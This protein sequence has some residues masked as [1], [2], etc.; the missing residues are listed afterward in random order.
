MTVLWYRLRPVPW[1]L[2]VLLGAVWAIA[3]AWAGPGMGE[4][5]G[6]RSVQAC[7][8]VLGL[9]GAFL[10]SAETDPPQPILRSVPVGY[11]R[12]VAVRIAAW[13][14]IGLAVL[15]LLAERTAPREQLKVAPVFMAAAATY[16]LAVAASVLLATMAGS[17]VGGCLA[18]VGLAGL[19]LAGD[20]WRS[21]PVPLLT[22]PG[23]SVSHADYR[24][25]AL[26]AV[27]AGLAFWLLGR[28][29]GQSPLRRWP[30]ARPW[31]APAVR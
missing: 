12:A 4:L 21:D 26:A 15:A 29:A 5:A 25:A 14:V 17:Y 19:A 18:L 8:L 30:A 13:A 10:V 16:L 1:P 27:L 20:S 28:G 31:R 24:A 22:V 2:L 23:A 6:A 7:G 3:T 11:W 9:G